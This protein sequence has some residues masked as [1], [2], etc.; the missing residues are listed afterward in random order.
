[1]KNLDDQLEELFE[2]YERI[3]GQGDYKGNA[4]D[5]EIRDLEISLGA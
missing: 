1:M 2:R 3:A 4:S 5:F